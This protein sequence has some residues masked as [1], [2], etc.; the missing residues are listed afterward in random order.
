MQYEVP[1]KCKS[2]PS[3]LAYGFT[4]LASNIMNRTLVYSKYG[5]LVI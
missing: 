5:L 2:E 4:I 1:D 3:T